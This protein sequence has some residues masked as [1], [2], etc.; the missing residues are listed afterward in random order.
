MISHK[1]KNK[2]N[3]EILKKVVSGND[4]NEMYEIAKEKIPEVKV[5]RTYNNM[6]TRYRNQIQ[7]LNDVPIIAS[8]NTI[9]FSG[10]TGPSFIIDFNK[11]VIVVVMCNVMHNTKL[12]RVDRKKNTDCIIE[13]ICKQIY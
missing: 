4:I 10:F 2:E 8:E 11:K 1:E 13:E 3:F 9:A 5:M 12:S 6:G 7:E